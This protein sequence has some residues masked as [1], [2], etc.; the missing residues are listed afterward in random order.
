MANVEGVSHCTGCGMWVMTMW[1]E[2]PACKKPITKG[3]SDAELN[4][5]GGIMLGVGVKE[6]GAD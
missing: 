2:C 1:L 6:K 4:Q 5:L 3:N